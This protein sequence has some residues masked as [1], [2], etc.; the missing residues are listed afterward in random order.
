MD[1]QRDVIAFLSDGASYGT[2]GATVEQV[3]THCSIIFLAGERAF[4][5]KRAVRFSYLDYSTPALRERFCRDELA[6][7]RR[8]A[9]EIYLGLRSIARD[10]RGTLTFDGEGPAVD[11]VVEMRRFAE[12]S[13]FSR[14]AEAGR[15]TPTLLRSL[16]DIIA[17]FHASAEVVR[18]HGGRVGLAAAIA[19]NDDNLRLAAPPFDRGLIDSLRDGSK[20]R[21]DRIGPLLE[22]RREHGRVRRCHGDLH[23]RNICL[24]DGRPTLFD[25]IEFN[26]AFS[27]IDVLYDLAFLLM[28]LMHRGLD[29]L[30]NLVFNRYLDRTGDSDGLPALPLFIS[31]RAAVRAHVMGILD[32]PDNAAGATEP[33]SYLNLALASLE[34]QSP[35]LIA[36][37]G[38][39]GSGK[40]TL[41]QALAAGFR[42]APGARV[43]RSDVVRKRLMHVPPETRLPRES[44]TTAASRDVYETLDREAATTLAAGYTAIVDGAFL[45]TGERQAIAAVARDAGVRFAGLWLE[46]PAELLARR[47][48]AR[49]NDASDADR[50]VLELQLGM[51]PGPLDWERIDAATGI[52]AMLAAARLAVLRSLEEDNVA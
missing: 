17:D 20:A 40:S 11:W 16:A 13:L 43:V 14:M 7:N 22:A 21:L 36:I 2:P 19:T 33:R 41:A 12:E 29:D 1:D 34:E 48:E 8:T 46:A 49:R 38:L 31:A 10:P 18:S 37:G 25:C 39:S 6:L 51:D 5:L 50:A 26:D 28:D 47:I 32:R 44:Y 9:P 42:P 24:F 27:C 30:A 45:R 52:T 15:L 4:K 3:V 35:R 23:L